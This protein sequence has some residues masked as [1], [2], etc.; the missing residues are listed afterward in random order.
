MQE[1]YL[2]DQG[3]C[4]GLDIPDLVGRTGWTYPEKHLEIIYDKLGI[5]G[6]PEEK[7]EILKVVF[8][9]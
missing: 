2:L 8:N 5:T 3:V 7:L 9:V 1:E 6:T 4:E